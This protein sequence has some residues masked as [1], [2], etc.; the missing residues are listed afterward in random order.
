M[1]VGLGVRC[2]QTGLY[3][4]TRTDKIIKPNKNY[5][6]SKM[7]FK[8]R[9]DTTLYVQCHIRAWFAR[10]RANNLRKIRDEKDAELRRKQEELRLEE[11][12]KRKEEIERRMQPKKP[13]DFDI[14]Y[15][16]LEAWRLNETKKIRNSTEL[17]VEEKN[18]ALQQL[19]NKETKILQ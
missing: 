5:F 2:E 10:R 18:L 6:H 3:M 1:D 9:E 16:E 19:L 7:W 15:N 14:L 17:N 11:E 12:R 13:K 8:E 4:D